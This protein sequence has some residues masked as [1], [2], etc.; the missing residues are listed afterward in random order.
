LRDDPKEQL[1]RELRTLQRDLT[2]P[3][4]AEALRLLESPRFGKLTEAHVRAVGEYRPIE[5]AG[6]RFFEPAWTR[7]KAA[8]AM[9]GFARLLG[10]EAV[11]RDLRNLRAVAGLRARVASGPSLAED[12]R[13]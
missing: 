10:A 9:L 4:L 7:S 12:A 1:K 2:E 13:E 5:I 8:G 3:S 6:E 11:S